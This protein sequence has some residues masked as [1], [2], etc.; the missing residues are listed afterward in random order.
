MTPPGLTTVNTS[1][2][3]SL[4]T[5]M[6]SV[7]GKSLSNEFRVAWSHRGTF[8]GAQDPASEEIPSLEITE[9]NMVGFAAANS[10][11]A[12]GLAAN[13]PNFG[14]PTISTRSRTM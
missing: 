7:L 9:L 2:E 12:I 11:T 10:R 5:W 13:L 14:R 3:H 6:N 8:R 4:N 1:N